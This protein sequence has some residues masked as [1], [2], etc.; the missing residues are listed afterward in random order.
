M[1]N[2]K[3]ILITGSDGSLGAVL[4]HHA[5]AIHGMEVVEFEEIRC[6]RAYGGMLD[7]IA[8]CDCIINNYGTNH[9][10]RI[11]ATQ[12][13]DFI[14]IFRANVEVP[15]FIINEAVAKGWPPATVLN[16]ASVT[17][18]V[19][20]RMTALYCASKAALVQMTKVMARELAPKGW[21]I[22]VIAPGKIFDTRMARQ[23]DKQVI[24]LRGKNQEAWDSYARGQ[25]PMGRYTNTAEV[26]EAVFKIL[27]MPPYLNGS[28]IDF[29][30]GM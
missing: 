4:T 24:E 26:A 11:G 23:T 12:P 14:N 22:N 29:T 3:R 9:L 25:I 1:L 27:E 19:P 30:G 8:P 21:V 15:Y 10:S 28:V 17:Y 18:R 16:V 13:F 7:G 5:K 20:Q 2:G 6:T